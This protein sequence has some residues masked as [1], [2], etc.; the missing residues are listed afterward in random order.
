M[1][2][3]KEKDGLIFSPK[4][5]CVKNS[6]GT[7]DYD[8]DHFLSENNRLSL[9]SSTLTQNI[10]ISIGQNGSMDIGSFT[11]VHSSMIRL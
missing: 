6:S 8:P 7:C 2:A 1:P 4:V 9:L 10:Y 11:L 3:Y 5:L